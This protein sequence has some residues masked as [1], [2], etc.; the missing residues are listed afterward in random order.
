VFDGEFFELPVLGPITKI[1][2]GDQRRD[3]GTVGEAAVLFDVQGRGVRIRDAAVSAPLLGVQGDG[4]ITLD[5]KLD[6]NV[7]AAPLANWRDKLKDT[8]IPLVSDVTAE[9]VGTVQRL[10]NSATRGLLYEFRVGGNVKDPKIEVVPAPALNEARAVVF[11]RMLGE[12]SKDKP[13][14]DSLKRGDD[15]V[16]A[17]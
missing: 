7:C 1:I 8:K 11:G 3:L 17:K 16:K 9:L 5:G 4:E 12:K 14:I 2:S 13:L 15:E 10:L 6:L